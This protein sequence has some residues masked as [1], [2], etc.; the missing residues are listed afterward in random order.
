MRWPYHFIDLTDAQKHQRR[1]LLDKHANIAQFSAIVPLLVIQLWSGFSWLRKTWQNHNDL[2]LPSSPYRKDVS[3]RSPRG[4]DHAR[5]LLR[6]VRWWLGEEQR[7]GDIVGTRGQVIFA[8]SWMV[9]LFWLCF[10]ETGDGKLNIMH[11]KYNIML[12]NSDYLHVTKRFGIIASSQLPFHYLLALKSPYSPLQLLTRKSHETLNVYHQFLGKAIAFLLYIHAVLYLNF[13]VQKSLLIS[14]IQELYVLCGIIGVVAFKIVTI[15]PF[16]HRKYRFWYLTHILISSLLLPLLFFH[17]SHLRVYLYEAGLIYAVHAFLRYRALKIVTATLRHIPTTSSSTDLLEITI[18]TSPPLQSYK[19]AQHTYLSLPHHPLSRNLNSN[20][21]TL[22]SLPHSDGHLRFLVRIY[23][24]NT[25]ALLASTTSSSG[26]QLDLTL[27]GPYGTSTHP[28]T[29]LGY[30]RVLFVAGGVGAAFIV[31]LYRQL[32][33][34]LSPSAGSHRRSKVKFVWAVRSAEE[35]TWAL[36]SGEKERQGFVERMEMYVTAGGG[37]TDLQGANGAP[38]SPRTSEDVEAIE[39]QERST[40]LTSRT[41]PSSGDQ[42]HY[43]AGRP[44]LPTI[45]H[46]TFSHSSTERVA[47]MVCGPKSLSRDLR[48]E[49]GNWVVGRGREVWWWEERFGW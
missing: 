23:A 35:T 44:D 18:P 14:K 30:D 16:K 22:A 28:D 39:L 26:G 43:R 46:E 10:A 5:V 21:F 29:L 9:W 19:T 20:P 33:E 31:P 47:V 11:H 38:V 3:A 15:P 45:V 1:E 24:G 12:K 4:L 17:V 27:E 7:L 48:R 41:E 42:F 2:D 25:A 8:L 49:V 37:G 6:K 40:L 34:D 36:P 13:Y 32:L